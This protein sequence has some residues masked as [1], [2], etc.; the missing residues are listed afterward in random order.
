MTIGVLGG[1][2]PFAT[3][4]FYGTLIRETLA[5]R[6]QAH[7]HVVIEA[8]PT[9][10]D[11]TEFLL[12]R[13]ADPRPALI[14]AAGRLRDAGATVIV[15]PCN[16]ASVWQSELSAA[17]GIRFIDWL[18]AAV[19][20][21][22]RKPG[23]VGVLATTGTLSTRLYQ[24]LLESARIPF[25]VPRV[26]DQTQLMDCIYGPDGVKTASYATAAA[27]TTFAKVVSGLVDAGASTLLLGCTEL[28]V[29]AESLEVKTQ[30]V[31]PGI[32]AARRALEAV[33][34]KARVKPIPERTWM[35]KL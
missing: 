18:D 10:P 19:S 33:G 13:G 23:V 7:P 32:E 16:T 8:D 34:A 5:D 22:A 11:R 29:L 2:G 35:P 6:D 21:V 25:V 28:P 17:V 4:L 15:M 31:D 27:T 12:G 26:T 1:M 20:M 9:I 3:Q 30:V 24:S 14:S